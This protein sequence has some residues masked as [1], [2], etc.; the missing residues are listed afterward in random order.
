MPWGSVYAKGMIS[1]VGFVK[2]SFVRCRIPKRRGGLRGGGAGAR[3]AFQVSSGR[4]L[5]AGARGTFVSRRFGR[6]C[7]IS[8]RQEA[9]TLQFSLRLARGRPGCRPGL[10][11]PLLPRSWLLSGTG[12]PA[13]S[14]GLSAIG[15]AVLCGEA[16]S[17]VHL[18]LCLRILASGG[19]PLA[20]AHAGGRV[21]L[22]R[23]NFLVCGQAAGGISASSAVCLAV[24]SF[25]SLAS[26]R[27]L[28]A[29][30]LLILPV[31]SQRP[32]APGR[33]CCAPGAMPV[34]LL[35]LHPSR[36]WGRV[37]FRL[38]TLVGY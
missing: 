19:Q 20:S 17:S 35:L 29:G 27:V 31:W 37:S 22:R 14:P 7:V 23:A 18:S 32:A 15:G 9:E 26:G 13:L 12:G 34:C 16:G 30:S 6:V 4:I 8:H 25:Q 33:S 38:P 21:C 10:L 11:E 5:T 24:C 1:D 36:G 2:M 28:G 3:G